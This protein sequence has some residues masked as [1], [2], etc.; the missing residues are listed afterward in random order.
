MNA[1][2]WVIDNLVLTELKT[3]EEVQQ[4][5][6]QGHYIEYK[7]DGYC[8]MSLKT[9]CGV[10]KLYTLT[11]REQTPYPQEWFRNLQEAQPNDTILIGELFVP[12]GISQDVRSVLAKEPTKTG[13]FEAFYHSK[14]KSRESFVDNMKSFGIPYIASP[15]E[16]N[17]SLEN[18]PPDYEGYVLKR[19]FY[20]RRI[21]G[22][23]VKVKGR[24]TCDLRI[25]GAEIAVK[26]RHIGRIKSIDC[27][28]DSGS[29]VCKVGVMDDTTRK[30]VTDNLQSCI[31]KII[32]V[33]Y[34]LR[35]RD[36][37]LRH[38]RLERFR[39]DKNRT[40]E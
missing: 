34:Q 27:A 36:G 31:G 9:V 25:T 19:D 5:R 6:T 14:S 32:E 4:W 22:H 37:S 40:T 15:E 35:T 26:G 23:W 1:V 21:T 10:H 33:G 17:L 7:R 11:P 18:L 38:P 29:I 16:T 20:P 30:F 8:L 39:E 13:I 24:E 2:T 12:G 28:S 3:S